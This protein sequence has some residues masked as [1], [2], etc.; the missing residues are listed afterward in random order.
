MRMKAAS[1]MRGYSTEMKRNAAYSNIRAIGCLAIVVL[2]TFYACLGTEG[3]TP[4]QR[5]MCLRVRNSMFWA[6]PCF[7]MVTGALLL[8]PAHDVTWDKIRRRY[9]PRILRAL[10]VFTLLFLLF[11]AFVSGEGLSPGLV[12]DWVMKMAADTGWSHMW[13]LYLMTALYLMLPFYRMITA[14]ASRRELGRLLLLYLVFQSVLPA[15][16][17]LWGNDFGFYLCVNTVYPLYLF[18]G[19]A[20]T[21]EETETVNGGADLLLRGI[22]PSVC[23][24]ALIWWFTWMGASAEGETFSKMVGNYSFPGVVLLSA[25]VFRILRRL[26][27]RPCRF[28]QALDRNSFGIYLIHMLFLKLGVVV[29]KV[30]PFILP[31]GLGVLLMAA[32]A[33]LLSWLCVE[34]VRRVRGLAT[35]KGRRI[36]AGCFL[37]AAFLTAFPDRSLAK[38]LNIKGAIGYAMVD[39]TVTDESGLFEFHLSPGDMFRIIRDEG[40]FWYV[41]AGELEGYVDS[42][43]CMIDL[44][45]VC[46]DILFEITNAS[47]SIFV[48]SGYPL[49]GITGQK[50]YSRGKVWHSK[51]GRE[52]YLVPIRYD[53]AQKIASVQLLA[54]FDGYTLKI[55]DAYRPRSV[56]MNVRDAL[57][58]LCQ[59]NSYVLQNVNTAPNGSYWGQGWFLAQS[60]SSHN[61]GAAIDVTLAWA[62]TGE[63]LAMPSPMHELS[64]AAVKYSS[65]GSYIYASTMNET[66]IMLDRYMEMA[67]MGTLASEWW[68]FQDN[69]SLARTRAIVPGGCDFQ[70]GSRISISGVLR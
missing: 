59:S 43:Y 55:Y 30:N 25:G 53:A 62:D 1:G 50:L 19:Y 37:A 49:D 45:D 46:P 17:K 11:D 8:D 69:D 23:G 48:S 24:L 65:P 67:G 22:L 41:E 20:I 9:L 51:I 44:A 26:A 35:G 57:N 39:M 52:E 15:A 5:L 29:M 12:R 61:F 27:N 3:I 70:A 21:S 31:G 33:A 40:A 68:H 64:T 38:D 66:A 13:Y 10:A 34:L 36:V 56:T 6:V 14:A 42:N 58:R 2:H 16:A 63:E 4:G 60:Q 7:V 18:A 47:S 28:L 32:A 54:S